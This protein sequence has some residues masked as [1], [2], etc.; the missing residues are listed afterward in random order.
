MEII[1]HFLH[2]NR[3]FMRISTLSSFLV[4]L[5]FGN[6]FSHIMV[7][8]GILKKKITIIEEGVSLKQAL[9][10]V[11]N[12]AEVSFVYSENFVELNE[13]VSISAKNTAV[14][15][16]LQKLLSPYRIGAH[17]YKDQI[18]LSKK[19]EKPEKKRIVS[20]AVAGK[21]TDN[22]T[23][24]PL[25]GASVFIQGTTYGDAT[26]LN[27]EY[28]I[29]NAPEGEQVL[30][31]TYI[32]YEVKELPIVVQ[33]QSILE[34]NIQMQAGT[35]ELSEVVITGNLEGQSRALNQQRTSD[36]IKNIISADLIGRFPDLN[37]SEALQ[38][39]PGINIGRDNGE[40]SSVQIRGTP[41]NYTSI[42]V[43]GEQLPSNTLGGSRSP[44]LVAYPVDQLGSIEV[45]KSITPDMDGDA[46]GGV[47]NMLPPTAQALNPSVKLEAGSGYNNL[48]KGVNGIGRASFGQRFFANDRVSQGRLGVLVSGSFFRTDNGE[49]RAES[50]WENLDYTT[51][52]GEERSELVLAEHDY[53]ALTTQRT[54]GGA[55]I[56]LDYKF[57]SVSDIKF[58]FMYSIL[59]ENELRSRTRFRMNNGN[60]ESPVLS[61]DAQVRKTFR[62]RVVQRDNFNYNLQGNF[63]IHRLQL[64]AAGFYTSS[65][66][67][68]DAAQN[69]FRANGVDLAV[70]DPNTQFPEIVSVDP[71]FRL[72]D[73]TIYDDWDNYQIYNRVN[74][75]EN[76]VARLNL[77]HPYKLFSYNGR[78]KGGYKYRLT[79]SERN[80]NSQVYEYQENS[81][82]L[83]PQ[84]ADYDVV[85]TDFLLGN[86]D[87]G[88]GTDPDA[89]RAFFNAN[90]DDFERN[91]GEEEEQDAE[92]FYDASETTNAAYLMTKLQVREKWMILA[93]LRYE[94]ISVEYEAVE[95][96]EEGDT[97]IRRPALGDRNYDFWLPNLQVKYSLNPLNNIRAA[98]TRSFA[99]P[100]FGDLV[101]TSAVNIEGENV[102]RGNP[103]LLPPVAWNFDLM[104]ERYLGNVGI[105]S[106]SGFY[107]IIDNFQF[108]N[109]VQVDGIALFPELVADSTSIFTLQEPDNGEQADVWGVEV[110][111]QTNLDFLPGILGG[112]GLYLNYTY[113]GS[114]AFTSDRTGIR[115]PGQADHTGNAALTF[116]YKG[117]SARASL[118]Y[119]DDLVD[120]LGSEQD[121]STDIIRDS[122]YQLDLNASQQ[123]N[124]RFRIYTEFINVTNRP[125]LEYFGSFDRI[126]DVG[127]FSWWC[128]FGLSYTL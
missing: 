48:S 86:V 18:I 26:D 58:N 82:G 46:I 3:Q 87:F 34:V 24:Q 83:F 124:D 2:E 7:G 33:E 84:F 17:L 63:L 120:A 119:Q 5:L 64:E 54:R 99:R 53:R 28:F 9:K 6:V 60:Q 29:V 103:N 77:T 4:L 117:F 113:T 40:G 44:T 125:Q 122:R 108:D 22:L 100:D 55:G 109:V 47:V 116:D 66:R 8:Q 21:V 31:V 36:N 94:N 73:A 78:I 50:E 15:N 41:L 80:R 14:K 106:L 107:K 70:L 90:R 101:P 52:G 45:T 61:T 128:R 118:N 74:R 111:I 81:E 69:D 121:G 12:L 32:G 79:N 68:E 112:L 56:N 10:R 65:E 57:S 105:L 19:E 96:V 98:I 91:T 85:S 67:D 102:N 43:N 97:L 39:I 71:V 11:E 30:V 110:N 62:D 115:L 114:D 20:G 72:E 13:T 123:I 49:D 35:D 126:R 88:P 37:V 104:F 59:E 51:E 16:V 42:Q 1:C 38:R 27:G 23:G 93:G 75:T 89:V 76:L 25:P 92:V 95:T 127:Y